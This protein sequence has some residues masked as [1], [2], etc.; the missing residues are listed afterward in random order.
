MSNTEAVEL[1]DI[2]GLSVL[3]VF[4]S[5]G[6]AEE[7]LD[8]IKGQ[9][10]CARSEN[11]VMIL[12]DLSRIDVSL[13][14]FLLAL[15]EL[16]ET[17]AKPLLVFDESGFFE[18]LIELGRGD[19][20]YDFQSDAAKALAVAMGMVAK[21]K[22]KT[23]PL[24]KPRILIVE[25]D[26]ETQRFLVDL[27][28]SEDRFEIRTAANGFEGGLLIP[29]YKPH[30]ILLDIMFPDIDGKEVCRLLRENPQLGN[31]WVIAVTA[32]SQDRDVDEIM[33]SGADDYL[34]KPF[35]IETLLQKIDNFI[36]EKRA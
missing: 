3:R 33:G 16:L 29:T 15:D 20:A 1:K 8:A 23:G 19:R 2:G 22:Q 35:R 5:A 13:S 12:H 11:I 34:G 4:C 6:K 17:V 9:L 31:P 21:R 25:D 30:V 24:E 27:L 26:P 28:E 36:G 7:I 32:L 10:S 14:D 18:S